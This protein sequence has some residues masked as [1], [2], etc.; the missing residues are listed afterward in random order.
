MQ[1]PLAPQPDGDFDKDFLD[2][3]R[4]LAATKVAEELLVHPNSLLPPQALLA[5]YQ[6]NMLDEMST[7]KKRQKKGA[8]FLSQSLSELAVEQP[9]L[10][11]QEVIDGIARIS[12]L[13][14]RIAVEEKQ[15]NEHVLSGGTI[16]EFAGVDDTTINCLYQGAK[17]LYEQDFLES[18][19][20]AFLFLTGL[21]PDMDVFWLGLGN[22]EF[23]RKNYPQAVTAYS[24]AIEIN[25]FN[26]SSHMA[27]SECYE[28]MGEKDK[29]LN[30]VV[31]ALTTI[32]DNPEYDDFRQGLEEEKLRLER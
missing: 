21:N 14:D 27:L 12:S 23:Y 6:Q 29:A 20:D 19:A 24:K 17:R 4:E 7:Y 1:G 9:E 31:L 15:F 25:P 26:P 3:C 32:Q 13:S 11:T 10:F 5:R 8:S 30:T 18:A 22:A 2:A 16:Q 28:T